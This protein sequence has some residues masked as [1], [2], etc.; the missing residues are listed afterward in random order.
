MTAAYAIPLLI[1]DWLLIDGTM[2]NHVQSAIDGS[3]PDDLD[4]WAD[5]DGSEEEDEE[6]AELPKVARVGLGIRRAGWDQIPGWP[7][8]ARGFQTWPAPGQM[9]TM[10][11][12]GRQW[13]L[14]LSALHF[15]ADVDESMSDTEGAAESRAAAAALRQRLTEVGWSPEQ[16]G[17]AH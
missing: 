10:T 16:P 15:W 11:L 5:D 1:R 8:D 2:D 9:A 7:H 14:V 12:T 4:E 17:R 6:D 3:V 13:E